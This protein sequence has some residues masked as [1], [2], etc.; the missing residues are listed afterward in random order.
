MTFYFDADSRTV[1][2]FPG[3]T[4]SKYFTVIAKK[5]DRKN[6]VRKNERERQTDR[7]TDRETGRGRDITERERVCH[8]FSGHEC[9]WSERCAG[10]IRFGRGT[11]IGSDMG[12]IEGER[13]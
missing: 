5:Y 6:H 8:V 13:W 1:K 12:P 2:V 10:E 4:L 11:L 3:L 7:Q 9:R